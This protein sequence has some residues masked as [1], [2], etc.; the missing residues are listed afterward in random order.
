MSIFDSTE[1]RAPARQGYDGIAKLLH[2]LI[3]LAVILLLVGGSLFKGFS[4]A[5]KT[6]RAAAGHA[7]LGILVLLLMSCRLGWRVMH[8]PPLPAAGMPAW[9]AR[10]SGLVH[11]C[12]YL[13]LFLQPLWGISLA[14]SS[15]DYEVIALGAIN[16]TQ[17]GFDNDAFY[18]VVRRLHGLTAQLLLLLLS[19]HIGAALDHHFRLKDGVLRRML[20]GI[21][22]RP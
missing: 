7:A 12:L 8:P 15:P 19:L 11:A 22:R 13:C 6:E 5:E 3:A 20:P 1:I 17:L 4:L 16:L 18:A 10:A 2:W 9:Q 14:L 21:R